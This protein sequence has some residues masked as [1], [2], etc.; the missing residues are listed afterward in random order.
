MNFPRPR[1]AVLPIALSITLERFSATLTIELPS[2]LSLS[3]SS[4]API[5][6]LS[7]HP[8]FT[9]QLNT[10]SLLG[11]KAKLQD[12]PKIEQLILG[13]IRGAIE[14]KIVLPSRIEI[15]LPGLLGKGLIPLTTTTTAEFE[16]EEGESGRVKGTDW[17]WVNQGDSSEQYSNDEIESEVLVNGQEDTG[18]LSAKLRKR[19]QASRTSTPPLPFSLPIPTMR[20]NPPPPTSSNESLPGHMAR[21]NSGKSRGGGGEMRYRNSVTAGVGVAAGGSR[22]SMTGNGPSGSMFK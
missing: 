6:H 14:E 5:V 8:D 12:I 11:S 7:L 20:G 9:L 21:N 3:L 13:R 16:V 2:P 17:D 4:S 18:R 22:S 15:G 1:F 10:T 19:V